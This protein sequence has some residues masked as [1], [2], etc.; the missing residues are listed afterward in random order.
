M[1][2]QQELDVAERGRQGT[3]VEIHESLDEGMTPQ[4]RSSDPCKTRLDG[5]STSRC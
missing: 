1:S 2:K 3:P 5:G 4:R